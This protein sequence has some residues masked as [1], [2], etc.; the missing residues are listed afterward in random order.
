MKISSCLKRNFKQS[1]LACFSAG[2]GKS[3]SF[4]LIVYSSGDNKCF[5]IIWFLWIP[6]FQNQNNISP[7]QFYF[8]HGYAWLTVRLIMCIWPLDKIR[9]FC[10]FNDMRRLN[11]F[12]FWTSY[13]AAV[14]TNHLNSLWTC[15]SYQKVHNV[16]LKD[17]FS[18]VCCVMVFIVFIGLIF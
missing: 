6:A 1:K 2:V 8:E 14:S 5:S 15:I 18:V 9:V 10:N 7:T 4:I 16:S 12:V 17:F 3:N 11:Q 13:I